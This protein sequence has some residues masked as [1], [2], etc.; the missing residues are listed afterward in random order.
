MPARRVLMLLQSDFP[1]DMRVEK[2][3]LSLLKVG[4]SVW[5]LADNRSGRET[6]EYYKGIH[7]VRLPRFEAW[8][9]RAGKLMRQPVYP[10]PMWL[11][12]ARKIVTEHKID[13]IHAHDLPM[14]PF[15]VHIG[16]KFRRPVVLDFHENYPAAMERWRKPGLA[17]LTIR[18]PGMARKLENFVLRRADK[19]VV[20]GVEHKHLLVGRGVTP[21]NIHVVENTPY[22][23]LA[24]NSGHDSAPATDEAY[25][26]LYFGKLN[27]ERGIDLAIRAMPLL[28]KE[29]PNVRLTVVGDGPHQAEIERLIAEKSLQQRVL[30]TGWLS[31]EQ[32]AVYFQTADVCIM[33]HESNEALDIGAP[34]KLFEYMAFGKP[35]VVPA[36]GAVGRIVEETQAGAVFEPGSVESFARAVLSLRGREKVVGARGRDAILKRY[37]WENSEKSLLSAYKELFRVVDGCGPSR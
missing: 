33:P 37:N 1:P 28:A 24:E 32:A 20:V 30:L 5:I 15:G 2:E 10:N 9:E 16:T 34:N 26:L 12:A 17:G 7:V 36:A 3:A 22:R 6:Y 8:P 25:N 4:Y 21:S 31:I 19:I 18:N 11:A 27:P 13:V 23:S 14:A 35:V 29:I